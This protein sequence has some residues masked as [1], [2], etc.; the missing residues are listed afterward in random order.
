MTSAA[1]ALSSLLH[2]PGRTAVSVVGTAFAVVLVF[3]QLGFLGAVEN[4]ATLLYGKMRFDVLVTSGEY[5]DLSRPGNGVGSH[6]GA[7]AGRGRRG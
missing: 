5:V 7:G 6:P 3:T 2:Q 4:T 1:L